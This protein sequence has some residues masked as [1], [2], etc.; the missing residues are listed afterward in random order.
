M[1]LFEDFPLLFF[2][3]Y[4][5]NIKI[6]HIH[7]LQCTF[8]D[9]YLNSYF[10]RNWIELNWIIV[11]KQKFV[12][13]MVITMYIYMHIINARFWLVKN[14]VAFDFSDLRQTQILCNGAFDITMDTII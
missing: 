5:F 1:H 10:F 12:A 11:R 13:H 2:Q 9:F 3:I 7:I 4:Q 8:C 6:S 14:Q